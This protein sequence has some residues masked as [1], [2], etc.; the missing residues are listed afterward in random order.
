MK[1]LLTKANRLK[2]IQFICLSII[3]CLLISLLSSVVASL[4]NTNAHGNFHFFPSFAENLVAMVLVVPF[5]ETLLLWGIKAILSKFI[6]H[7]TVILFIMAITFGLLHYYSVWYIVTVI[8]L[9]IILCYSLLFYPCKKSN[10]FC[11]TWCIHAVYNLIS[12][13]MAFMV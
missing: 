2:D 9:G 10:P 1:Y 7:K 6:D 5:V 3:I 12:L 8:F 4:F 13:L 11:V